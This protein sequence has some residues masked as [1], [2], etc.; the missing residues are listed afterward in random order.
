M[1]LRSPYCGIPSRLWTRLS[2]PLSGLALGFALTLLAGCAWF[3]DDAPSPPQ[4]AVPGGSL[5]AAL[6][7]VD[8]E[9]DLEAP[10]V[11]PPPAKDKLRND[12]VALVNDQPIS[13][14]DLDQ[15][16]ALIMVT[17]GIPNT[18]EMKRKVREQALEQLQTELIQ[19]QE[20]QKND[21][22]VSSVDVDKNIKN[23]L[24][25]SR[26]TMD[27]LKE[28]LARGRVS[29][30]AFRAQ[31]AAQFLWQKLVQMQ[32]A[33]RVNIAPEIVD[34][35]LQRYAE[36]ASK[37]HYAVAE[38]FVAVD[39]PDQDAKARQDALNYYEQILSGAP[40][41]AIARQFSQS[42]SAAQGGGIGVV[43]D[44]QLAPELNK[45]LAAMKTGDVSPPIRAIGGYYI[46]ALQQR[47]E[48]YGTKIEENKPEDQALPA[49]L[50]LARL[51][52]P[53]PPRPSKTLSDNALKIALTLVPHINGCKSLPA[54]AKQIQGSVYMD[55]GRVR[56]A[57]LSA[58]I[59]TILAKT[60]SGGVAAPF[61]SDAG[62][63]LFVRCDKA[64]PKLQAFQMPTREQIEQQLFEEQ[65]SAMARRYNR[66]LKRDADIEVR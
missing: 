54:I 5:D 39:N 4:T 46:L 1:Q 30:S 14:Y 23:I 20:A 45:M 58:Q 66:D 56:L 49:T 28:I 41:A 22:T 50:P 52:L 59:R 24:S 55:L 33:P 60:E 65:I 13:I 62:A 27:Q 32:Y 16:T 53:L 11:I 31:I 42:P 37:T 9:E 57:D 17:S 64:V 25:D 3:S 18:P 63:E 35:E 51:L 40:F 8:E 44:G 21:I 38:I 48:P 61:M 15:R 19:R 34:A 26:L 43:Y 7:A 29:M 12:I 10:R 36:S 2:A 47:L 6:A